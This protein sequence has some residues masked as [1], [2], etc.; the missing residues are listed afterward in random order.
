M[1]EHAKRLELD[2]ILA[3]CASHAVLEAGKEKILALEPVRTVGEAKELLD[4]T[5]EA[6]LLLFTLGSG[7][8]EE[9]PACEDS[10]AR[11]RK[12]ATLS[13]AELLG[14]ARLLRAAR[15]LYSSVR[16]FSDERI[17][18]MRFLTE[19][20]MF[21][22]N[23]EEDIGRKI[24]NENELSDHASEK[25]FSLRSQIRQLGER[26]RARLQGY[27]AGEEKKYLQDGIVTVRGDRF[28]IPVKAEYKRSVK[29]FV[30]DRSQSGA[31]VFVEPEEVLEMNNELRGLMLDEREEVERILADL[32]RAVGRMHD[33][34]LHDMAVLAEAD[35]FYARAE[36]AYSVK[37][38]K[39]ALGGNGMVEIIKG[40]HPLLDAKKAVPVTLSVGGEYR[41]LLISGANTGGKTVTLKMCGL[42]C[43]MAACGLFV[44][45]A[46]GTRL[47]VFDNVWC[48]VGDSQSIEENLS[49]FSSHVAHLKEILEGATEKSLVLID[50][51]GGGTDP[52]EGAALARAVLTDLLRR[53]CRGIVTTH[54]SSLKEFAYAEDGIENGCMEFDAAD[55]RPLYRLKIGA[56]GSSNALLIC[57]RLGLPAQTI[58]EARGYLSEGA[59]SFEHTLRA[60]EESRVQTEAAMQAARKQQREWEQRLSELGKEEE[61]F[62]RERERFLASSKAEAR[63][64]VAER[65]ADAEELLVEMEKIFEKQNYSE[66]DLIRARTLKNKLENAPTEEEPVRAVPVDAATLNVGDLVMV[67][68]LGTEGA[69]LSVRR[70]KGMCDVQAGALR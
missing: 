70:E 34:L 62:R 8:V 49:T 42:F 67:G 50:E 47:A 55:F 4:L 45:A 38:V 17:V 7:K 27:L 56:P 57:T 52:E 3:A 14:V 54:Y 10:L 11:A 21:D 36:Y 58:E 39:P 35:S 26:I 37:G 44:P 24:L 30:H 6:S 19:H 13:M 28:V 2:K 64:I 53:G 51:P 16:S 69:V 20:L 61:K 43:L 31:T 1:N 68:S 41:F 25:L 60:A 5:E 59:R 9:F 46:E 63:R 23:L 18:K 40:R 48:D 32:S 33:A 12:G 15:V 29:G 22:R 65:T 66:A